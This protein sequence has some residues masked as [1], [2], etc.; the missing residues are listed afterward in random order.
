MIRLRNLRIFDGERVLEQRAIAFDAGGIRALGEAAL[1]S[2]ASDASIDAQ[3]AWLLPGLM[4]CHV[5]MELNPEEKAP[6]EPD[7]P[8]DLNAMAARA[9]R[10]LE[11]G[12]T[13]A[14]D[15]GGGAGAELVLRDRI[16]RGELAGPRLLCAGQPITSV[17]GHCHF[18]G[19]AAGTYTEAM[20]VFER[21]RARGA[22]LLKIMATGGRFT[23]DSQPHRAQFSAAMIADLIAAARTAGMTSAAHCHGSEGIAHAAAAGV[24]S[25]EHCSWVGADGRWASD[26]RADVVEA[27]ARQ[28]CFVSPT[29]NAGWQRFLGGDNRMREAFRASY[30]GLREQGVRLVASTDAGIPGVAHHHLPEALDVFRQIARLSAAET[31]T[32]ATANAAD[33]L[34]ISAVTGRVRVGLAADLLLVDGNP[35]EDLSVLQE[36]LAIW[37]GGRTVKALP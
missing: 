23:P 9:G 25:I 30:D 21:Q 22:D 27:M 5:H 36:P 20:Q 19:G 4:D 17:G 7:A 18:W 16:A 10:M 26:Y 11:R 13:T 6:P 24:T 35:T 31:L 8:R 33:A 2:T 15:L 34:G 1:E 14:R 37:A 29:V 32:T 3:G 12:I 28:G